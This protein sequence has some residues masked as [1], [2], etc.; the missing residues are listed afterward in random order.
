MK[1]YVITQEKLA[2]INAMKKDG[3]E[4]NNPTIEGTGIKVM[5]VADVNFHQLAN[6]HPKMS[7]SE[8]EALVLSIA[9]IGQKEP[10]KMYKKRLMVDGRHRVWALKNLGV[11]N[12]LYIDLPYRMSLE[13]VRE[14]VLSSDTR[15]HKTSAQRSVQ[16]Y[17]DFTKNHK[18][19][20][21][22]QAYYATKYGV[23]QASISRCRKIAEKLGTDFLKEMLEK[24]TVLLPNGRYAKS[25][26]AVIK[27]IDDIENMKRDKT[28]RVVEIP[29][30]LKPT[31]EVINKL[32][33]DR[34]SLGLAMLLEAVKGK[35]KK[36]ATED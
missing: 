20:D 26:N 6:E 5:K 27:Y 25:I 24:G 35:I 33:V 10:I 11:E 12:V 2:E 1:E 30:T 13:D 4:N 3:W 15:R 31:M 18:A 8:F 9:E 34:D 21:N 16:A 29:E 32:Y 17:F 28:T 22:S 23:G 36:I 7:Q 14:E 19:D